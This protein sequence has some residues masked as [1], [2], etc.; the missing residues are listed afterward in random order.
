MPDYKPNQIIRVFAVLAL[1]AALVLV[2]VVI[3]TTGGG[4]SGN[5]GGGSTQKSHISKAGRQAVHKGVW[6]VRPGDTLGK[7][8][9][10]TGIAVDTLTQLNPEVDPQTLLEGQQIKLTASSGEAGGGN[11]GAQAK[12]PPALSNRGQAAVSSGVW[13]VRSGDTLTSISD[14]TRIPIT[15]LVQ[16]NPGLDPQTLTEGQRIAL[17]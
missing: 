10:K 13:I 5:G 11:G 6:I 1:I 16:L 15:T 7:I 17:R 9:L 8:S 2:V 4:S 12:Q 14:E 3:V